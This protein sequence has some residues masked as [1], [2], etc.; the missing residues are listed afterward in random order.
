[1]PGEH[2]KLTRD[3]ALAR[4]K[5]RLFSRDVAVK[6]GRY[7]LL[8]VIGEG[9]MGVVW[10]AWDPELDRRVAIK[11]VK[12][13]LAAARERMAVEGQALARLSHPHVVPIYDVGT[14]DDQVYLVMEWIRGENLRAYSRVPRTV[15][16]LV[17]VYT[18]AGEG[19][20][21]AHAVGLVHR[22]FKPE[23]A[24]RGEDGRVR[25]LD[26]G[27]A[28]DELRED[29]AQRGGTPRYMAP[30]QVRG[31]V[32]AACDQYAFCVALREA[33]ARRD[34]A[35]VDT[36]VPRWLDAI[37]ARGIQ[38][39]PAARFPSMRA[40]LVALARNPARVARRRAIAVGGVLALVVA[41]GIGR[42]GTDGSRSDRCAGAEAELAPVWSDGARAAVTRHMSGLGAYA[43]EQGAGASS[44]LDRYA[45][46]WAGAHR[47]ACAAHLRGELTDALYERRLVCLSQARAALGTTAELLATVATE[48]VDGG[49]IAALSLPD[50]RRC[51]EQDAA[52][53]APP[54]ALLVPVVRDIER[55]TARARVLM[56]ATD[57]RAEASARAVV[58]RAEATGYAPAI[59]RARL[60][61]GRVEAERGLPGAAPTLTRAVHLAIEVGDDDV[62]VE[63]FARLIWVA[64][65]RDD[66]DGLT[67]VEPMATRAS[68]FARAL[69]YNNLATRRISRSDHAGARALLLRARSALPA[70]PEQVDIELVC[71]AQ[72]LALAAETP[73]EREREYRAAAETYERVLGP[74]N[75]KSLEARVLEALATDHPG[76]ARARLERACAGYRGLTH[77]GGWHA[78]CEAELGWIADDAGDVGAAVAAMRRA[79]AE[80]DRGDA[81]VARV[82]SAYVAAFA[83]DSPVADR[84]RAL[85]SVR[86]VARE[87]GTAREVWKQLIAGDA[88][89]TAARVAEQLS[90]PAAAAAAWSAALELHARAD[91]PLYRRRLSRVRAAVAR[92]QARSDPAEARHLADLARAW[93]AAAGGYDDALRAL[94]VQ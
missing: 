93:Y 5:R 60:V 73:G 74:L 81:N 21:A 44:D 92:Y 43:V 8:E 78:W 18:Q 86:V 22:D 87:F 11:L 61:L 52:R 23:N 48:H 13:S 30:E 38:V 34:A 20:A 80:G 37:T 49:R 15:R 19:L 6:L 36:E 2:A 70:N 79:L 88:Y 14:L 55:D 28:G 42:A 89:I 85:D 9:G 84:R 77:L 72:N 16:E 90:D 65:A 25:V 71:I 56:V 50:P 39:D 35:E 29:A 33:L 27:L 3:V 12:P 26:F 62:A 41:F 94:M 63:A 64:E 40:L 57:P 91:A 54:G 17:G 76:R 1:M 75:A 69:L 7:H 66:V 68:P 51:D 31:E 53:V 4:L 82:L 59:A 32:S 67:L 10:G 24:I 83:P 47:A 45:A 46:A 58:E